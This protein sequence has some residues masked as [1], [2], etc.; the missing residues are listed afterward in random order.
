MSRVKRGAGGKRDGN[1]TPIVEALRAIGCRV[2]F[3]SGQGNPDLLVYREGRYYPME[4]KQRKGTLTPNQADIP[5]PIVRSVD[6]AIRVVNGLP[7]V[8]GQ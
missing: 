7:P 3:L 6:E 5:W 2:W 4:T 1:E 8:E